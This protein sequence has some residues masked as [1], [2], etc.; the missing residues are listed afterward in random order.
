MVS[1]HTVP[2]AQKQAIMREVLE[3]HI[4]PNELAKKYNIRAYAIREW[5]KKAGHTLPKNYKR[6]GLNLFHLIL[7]ITSFVIIIIAFLSRV[8]L[9]LTDVL[10]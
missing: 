2:E 4:S 3:D 9:T 7:I 5:I 8:G 10:F 6:F 1:P